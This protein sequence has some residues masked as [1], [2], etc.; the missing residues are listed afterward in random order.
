M[1]NLSV[2]IIR[3]EEWSPSLEDG[4]RDLQD[5]DIDLWVIWSEARNQVL[6]SIST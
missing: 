2:E 6:L 5:T 3:G 4:M 1:I